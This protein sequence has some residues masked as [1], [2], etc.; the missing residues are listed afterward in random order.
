MGEFIAYVCPPN[1]NS[2]PRHQDTC[3]IRSQP[4]SP[5]RRLDRERIILRNPRTLILR[6]PNHQLLQSEI[7][8]APRY[9]VGLSAAATAMVIPHPRV[10]LLR[11]RVEI[12]YLTSEKPSQDQ[13][14]SP[15]RNV[16][17]LKYQPQRLAAAGTALSRPASMVIDCSDRL[18]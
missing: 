6:N 8:R 4:L 2:S 16:P 14:S 7:S 5:A 15:Q 13:T 12:N 9:Q 10:R 3:S 11:A 17:R 18:T 1:A